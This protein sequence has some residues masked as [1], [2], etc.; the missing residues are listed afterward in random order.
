EQ[1]ITLSPR[2]SGQ[3]ISLAENFTPGGYVAKGEVLLQ[4]DPADYET[5]VQQ[6]R[7][8]LHQAEAELEMEIGRQEQARRDYEGLK[9]TIS[10]R[11]RTLVL[12]EP[13]LNAAQAMVESANAALRQAEL[14]LERTRVR[15]PFPAHVL[16]RDAHIG[17]QVTPSQVLGRL[18]GI[19]AYWVEASVPVA[20]L[21]WIAFPGAG[22]Q[23]TGA[24]A[25]VRNRAAWPEDMFRT[26]RVDKLVGALENET[27]M[28]RVLIRVDDPLAQA[29]ESAGLPP[30]MVG[31]FVEVRIEG[32][33][34]ENVIRMNRAYLR[35]NDTVWVMQDG[36]LRI[37]PVE[38]EFADDSHVYIGGGL[39]SAAQVVTTNLATVVEGASLR[40][41]G[42]AP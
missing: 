8:E 40:L 2:V 38:V 13:Q 41:A 31:S 11:Y 32:K 39:D 14:D 37:L 6:R 9:G 19:E 34:I 42:E 36:L 30:L 21:R 5:V 4:I 33:P 27:R 20:S 7:S 15:A 24:T 35:Q 1:E 25:L 18:V 22:E 10:D 29:P 23:S 26:G 16:S 28:A 17:S 12:R 3:V